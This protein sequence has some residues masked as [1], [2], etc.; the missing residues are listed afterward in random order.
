[1]R[2]RVRAPG[3]GW[4]CTWYWIFRCGCGLRVHA[5]GAGDVGVI[6]AKEQRIYFNC[7]CVVR[8]RVEYEL[9]LKRFSKTFG[10]H[11]DMYFFGTSGGGGSNIEAQMH[12]LFTFASYRCLD[13]RVFSQ[14]N[15]AHVKLRHH[16]LR[17]ARIFSSSKS[18]FS[19]FDR[20]PNLSSDS[21]YIHIRIFKQL[22]LYFYRLWKDN[23]P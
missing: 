12:K 11:T 6:A 13:D 8:V 9:A 18:Q 1:M 7:G 2:V 17:N 16:I 5:A 10:C 3:A 23:L 4:L 22:H 20:V 14:T 15:P 19:S 21:C